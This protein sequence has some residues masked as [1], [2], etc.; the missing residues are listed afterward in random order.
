MNSF[1]SK[2]SLSTEQM[3]AVAS[4]V[5]GR[6]H[7][8]DVIRSISTDIKPFLDHDHFDAALLAEDGQ[9]TVTFEA[10]LRTEWGGAE[11][12]VEH[13]P[14]RD[15]L[16]NKVDYIVTD[17]A[18]NDPQFREDGMYSKPIF[19][20]GLRSRLHLPIRITGE[21]IGALSFSRS[22]L[23]PFKSVD[24]ANAY[25]I[26]QIV[27]PYLHGLLERKRANQSRQNASIE[28]ER[29]KGLKLGVRHLAG[30]MEKTRTQIGMD[31]HDQ[32]LADL[33]RISRGI[34]DSSSLSGA[35][36]GNLKHE[37]NLCITELRN[38]VGQVRP[39]ILELFG[40]GEAVR[41]QIDKYISI[42]SNVKVEFVD[43]MNELNNDEM[44]LAIFRI[45]QEAITNAFKHSGA[46]EIHINL[47]SDEEVVT[48]EIRD[49][50]CGIDGAATCESGGLFFMRTRALLIG[51]NLDI[52]SDSN[53]A[54]VILTKRL[55][56]DSVTANDNKSTVH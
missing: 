39:S 20:A 42:Q 47:L 10:G 7:L 51:A 36:L 25:A 26:S 8:D 16:R 24:V 54:H 31:L 35:E 46:D 32:T 38:I 17:D 12:L 55:H 19:S 4:A 21:V 23:S 9:A 14:I 29:H 33:S 49:N 50:G 22:D 45:A 15:L 44:S 52:S 53:G 28:A 2:C 48:F 11:K 40:L 3:L 56:K 41:Q 5:A 1:F 37:L 34:S 18:Q 30:E 13:S 6:V 43:K 27:G